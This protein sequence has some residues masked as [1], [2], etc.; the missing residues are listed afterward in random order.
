M[1]RRLPPLNALRAFEAAARFES[2]SAAAD[3]LCVTHGAVS[4]QVGQLEAWLGRDLFERRGRR[5]ALTAQGRVYLSEISAALDRIALATD[6]QLRVTRQQIIRVNAPTTFA[7]RWLLPQLSSFQLTNP[8]VEVR[9]TTSDE[10][11]EKLR[12]EC[13]VAIR[14]SEQKAAGYVVSEFLSEV[15]LP[16]CSP[17]VLEVHPL[18]RVSDLA[19]HTLLHTATYPGLWDEW[20]AACGKPRLVPRNSQQLDHFYLTLQAAIDGL[21]I[22]MGPTALVAL[23]VEEGRLVFPF[24]GP[25]LPAWRYCSYVHHARLGDP[26]IGIF[27]AWLRELGQRFSRSV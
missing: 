20:L 27:L 24:D 12:E 8:A 18:R 23:D 25:A 14:G 10:P 11:I 19:H 9:L 13:D 4:R 6:E 15:R 3:E 21:G 16:V 1:P 26:A 7:L 5:V 22:A 2:F 17:K